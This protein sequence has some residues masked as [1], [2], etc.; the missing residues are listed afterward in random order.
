MNVNGLQRKVNSFHTWRNELDLVYK[1]MLALGFAA[2]T[3]LMAQVK[4]GLPFTPI[5]VTG[6]TFA[7]LLAGIMLGRW[8]AVSMGMYVGLG[9]A[10][11]PWFTSMQGGIGYFTGSTAGYL[12]GFV[13]AAGF[14]GLMTE[15]YSSVKDTK[16]MLGMLLI[17]N[18]VLIYIPGLFFLHTWWSSF[19]GPIGIV[20]LIAVGLV[21]FLVGDL[22][23]IALVTGIAKVFLPS[24]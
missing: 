10:G 5:P 1:I 15:R 11:I 18:F 12:L 2:L 7:V 13:L 9:A 6:Q 22:L 3:G 20:Q 8:G 19:I 14:I 17:A 23:K 24:A 16:K 21:P 4:V